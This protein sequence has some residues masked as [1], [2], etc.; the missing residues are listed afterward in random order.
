V[1]ALMPS[2]YMGGKSEH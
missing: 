2:G 1:I